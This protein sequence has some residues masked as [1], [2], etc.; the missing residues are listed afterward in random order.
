M[1]TTDFI[2][3]DTDKIRFELM[4]PIFEEAMAKVLTKGAKKYAPNNWKLGTKERYIG[5][6]KRH[7]NQRLQGKLLDDGPGG[8]NEAHT[9]QIAINAMFLWWL[10]TYG[11]R[12]SEGVRFDCDGPIQKE[13]Q[14]ESRR[15]GNSTPPQ[16]GDSS[17]RW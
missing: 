6:I 2:K 13:N 11:E 9:A 16:A 14:V 3:D 7:L 1:T 15:E 5:A 4:D 8:I 17:P 10:D 12:K